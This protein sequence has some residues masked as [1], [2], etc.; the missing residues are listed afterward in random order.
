[1]FQ[2]GHY[3]ASKEA[4]TTFRDRRSLI[5]TALKS[6]SRNPLVET[7]SITPSTAY[8][9]PVG[10]LPDVGLAAVRIPTLGQH[11]AWKARGTTG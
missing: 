5:P 1:M 7:T 2:A 10:F 4:E 3:R 11:F 8:A 6:L 9:L